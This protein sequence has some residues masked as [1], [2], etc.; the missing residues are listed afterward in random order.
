M[1][2][3]RSLRSRLLITYLLVSA[4]VLAIVG[5]ALLFFLLTNPQA[6][7]L[8]YSRIEFAANALTLR[9]MRSLLNGPTEALES[10]L[11]RFDQASN[12][13][14]LILTPRGTV[15]A[16]SRPGAGLPDEDR[17]MEIAS[18]PQIAHDEFRDQDN[19][20]WLF[21]SKPIANGH[22]LV[23]A[24]PS[25]VLRTL[26]TYSDELLLKP[27]V[28]AGIVA[29]VVSFVF[30]WLISRWVASPLQSVS[31]AAKA[32]AKGDYSTRPEPAGPNE[33]E[34]LAISFNEMVQRVQSSQLAQRDFVANV[35]H[36]LKTPLTSI[37]G[38]A[39][40]ILDGTAGDAEAQ[41][42]AAGVIFNESDR[43]RRLV[44]DLL[45]LA[46]LDTGQ[47]AFERKPIDLTAL[48][49]SVVEKLSLHASEKGVRIENHI[50]SLPT[51]IGD[52][53]RLAQVFTNLVDNAVK[54]SPEGGAVSLRGEQRAGVILVHV[55]DQGP[56]IPDA[57]LSRIFE[58]F[59]QLD[60]ARSGGKGRGVGLGLAISREIVQAHHGRLK[61]QSEVG[62]GSRF[63]VELPIARHDDETLMQPLS[64]G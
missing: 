19:L 8:A 39:Q 38:F 61:A 25:P 50:P 33:V 59:Y 12:V 48:L 11:Q 17:L 21:S 55:D 4:L 2:V 47:V 13:R 29:L 63:T 36:E 30:A 45:D 10:A 20:R 49:D 54:H 9:D 28:Q 60:K 43:L 35:S 26:L 16:D 6:Q 56:G 7:R 52:G 62:K 3:F 32:V 37:Q 53:D 24:V 14:I 58:R 51:L 41:R 40:A 18:S 27:L 57:E 64:E 31:R 22:T 23:V 44:D 1:A 15:L 5:I 46:K 34:S 42:H